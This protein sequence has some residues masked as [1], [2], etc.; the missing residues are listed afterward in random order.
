MFLGKTICSVPGLR[1]GVQEGGGVRAQI[2]EPSCPVRT[3]TSS[4][5]ASASG[6]SPEYCTGSQPM[7]GTGL[8]IACLK[9]SQ[10]R[11]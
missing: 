4:F 3:A 2:P 6:I 10:G 5:R 1:D 7:M 11:V 8:H 9:N